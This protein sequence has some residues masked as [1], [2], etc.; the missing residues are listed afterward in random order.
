MKITFKDFI[1][2]FYTLDSKISLE[3]YIENNC[4]NIYD[5]HIMLLDLHMA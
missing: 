3:L 2:K 1:Q 5:I 4:T